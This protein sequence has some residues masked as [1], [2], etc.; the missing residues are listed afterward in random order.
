MTFYNGKT[1]IG[2]GTTTTGVASLTTSFSKAGTYTIKANYPGD[3]FHKKSSG[4]VRQVV[5]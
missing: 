4:S 3:P 1:A 5:N 2:T